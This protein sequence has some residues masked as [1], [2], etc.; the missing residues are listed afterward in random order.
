MSSLCL[1]VNSTYNNYLQS[2]KQT[3]KLSQN[4]TMITL[5]ADESRE[6]EESE[7]SEDSD[8]VDEDE[9]DD[10]D[11]YNDLWS[12]Q[13]IFVLVAYTLAYEFEPPS[14]PTRLVVEPHIV[15]LTRWR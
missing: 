9:E 12:A 1:A 11:V 13:N 6:T 8:A 3:F 10:D 7:E 5:R 2:H 4:E 14:L 15:L